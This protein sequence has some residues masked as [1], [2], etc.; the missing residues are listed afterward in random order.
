MVVCLEGSLRQNFSRELYFE[1]VD[2]FLAHYDVNRLMS[3]GSRSAKAVY[4]K[5]QDRDEKVSTTELRSIVEQHFPTEYLAEKA[6]NHSADHM[7][8]SVM[9]VTEEWSREALPR[10]YD[11]PEIHKII[12]DFTEEVHEEATNE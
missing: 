5:L 8:V 9:E 11:D 10:E 3:E 2:I 6:E 7:E 1:V 12:G 4:N